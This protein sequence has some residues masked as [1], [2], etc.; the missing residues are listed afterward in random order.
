MHESA[1]GAYYCGSQS[2]LL[3]C[4]TS[5]IAISLV[6]KNGRISNGRRRGGREIEFEPFLRIFR[7]GQGPK[8]T[9]AYEN[10]SEMSR[11]V[12][13][14]RECVVQRRYTHANSGY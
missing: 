9:L 7:D 10:P 13:V 11:E 6:D 4:D 12:S 5:R 1:I 8:V 2:A 3:P 14:G